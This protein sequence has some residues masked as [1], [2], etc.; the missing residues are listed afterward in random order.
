MILV[1]TETEPKI[2][3]KSFSQTKQTGDQVG[4]DQAGV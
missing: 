2:R 3:A 1:T 4:R